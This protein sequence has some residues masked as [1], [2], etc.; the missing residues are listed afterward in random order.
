[1]YPYIPR[2]PAFGGRLR[3]EWIQKQSSSDPNTK[4]TR[5]T[6]SEF[7]KNG[8]PIEEAI[9]QDIM[10]FWNEVNIV[11]NQQ[12]QD[13][14]TDH[15]CGKSFQLFK[16]IY[17]KKG[18]GILHYCIPPRCEID[19]YY[20]IIYSACFTILERHFPIL[21]QY[22][23]FSETT[24]NDTTNS[25]EEEVSAFQIMAFAVFALYAFYETNPL[26][27]VPTPYSSTSASNPPNY[28]MLPLHIQNI[29]N[30]EQNAFYR[31]CFKTPIRIARRQSFL[32]HQLRDLGLARISTSASIPTPPPAFSCLIIKDMIEI[33][34]RLFHR[35]NHMLEYCEYPGPGTLDG[36][37]ASSWCHQDKLSEHMQNSPIPSLPLENMDDSNDWIQ[38]VETD[39]ALSSLR[40][41][42][43]QYRASLSSIN[44]NPRNIHE[45]T[46][47]NPS[48]SKFV[49]QNNT[50]TKLL[51][52]RIQH[53]KDILT[54]LLVHHSNK[55]Q[56]DTNAQVHNT[57]WPSSLM[58]RL[59]SILDAAKTNQIQS[60]HYSQEEGIQRRCRENQFEI[61]KQ[62]SE[63]R[64]KAIGATARILQS[65]YS[66]EYSKY[67]SEHVKNSIGENIDENDKKASNHSNISTNETKSEIEER[68]QKSQQSL[69][70]D[71]STNLPHPSATN[72]IKYN[73]KLPSHFSNTLQS[74][75]QNVINS[76]DLIQ[77]AVQA[78]LFP[79]PTS[80]LSNQPRD[81]LQSIQ[82]EGIPILEN[83]NPH[84][85]ENE[86]VQD[87]VDDYSLASTTTGLGREA[88]RNLIS[89]VN[90]KDVE[91]DFV[92]SDED[93]E[94]LSLS[95]P[96]KV[97]TTEATFEKRM[98]H[99]QHSST[100]LDMDSISTHDIGQGRKAISDLLQH[101]KMQTNPPKTKRARTKRNMNIFKGKQAF[102]QKEFENQLQPSIS[103]ASSQGNGK[104]ALQQLLE[105]A[106]TK[107]MQSNKRKIISKPKKK[108]C[109]PMQDDVVS[110]Q[111]TLLSVDTGNGRKAL[112]QLLIEALRES[113]GTEKSKRIASNENNDTASLSN[114]IISSATGNG[115]SAL[116][117]L[118]KSSTVCSDDEQ[119][120]EES[121]HKKVD[122]LTSSQGNKKL[123]T[124][125]SQAESETPKKRRLNPMKSM[126]NK[127]I[128]L[129]DDLVS[130]H[131]TTHS[132]D[133]DNGRKAIDLLLAATERITKP[134]L[135]STTRK[136]IMKRKSYV[137]SAKAVLDTT[138]VSNSTVSATDN[139]RSALNQLLNSCAAFRNDEQDEEE[140][141]YSNLESSE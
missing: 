48:Q 107:S 58:N 110:L 103:F 92:T 131:Q 111:D 29:Y 45:P 66:E 109:P 67:Q 36:L 133:T 28:H 54:P 41:H 1:M 35:Q 99:I 140:S 127:S 86:F 63:H 4:K 49:K 62:T 71:E 138:S 10:D 16:K 53:V 113:K 30:H 7:Y 105:Q 89:K 6:T 94:S 81:E 31:R 84:V 104:L 25:M 112:D 78:N 70:K 9:L 88:L 137:S 95:V 134:A 135:K 59:E 18:M 80:L 61:N 93:E 11:W 42:F 83:T 17:R 98:P 74:A 64:P 121:T 85:F 101:A 22:F 19:A 46:S 33:I 118:L 60:I 65:K 75:I 132:I 79:I 15:P 106:E 13:N 27:F 20:Q 57:D 128:P 21:A 8:G 76:G 130:L 117:T 120:E 90:N 91:S 24:S 100:D 97:M 125:H 72:P 108:T 52:R 3:Q 68:M 124:R 32:L 126:T 26:P 119:N 69:I 102:T 39:I 44:L 51:Q 55:G 123:P 37:V 5:P 56:S 129:K 96:R 122:Y 136:S 38:E 82:I 87:F 34:D 50:R 116:N 43:H 23:A 115:R 12:N 114:S 141:I 139:G 77:E 47:N 2:A 14:H 73:L 40:S